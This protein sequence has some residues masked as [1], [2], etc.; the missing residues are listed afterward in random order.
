MESAQQDVSQRSHPATVSFKPALLGA[1]VLFSVFLNI[2]RFFPED[3]SALAF[4][5][6]PF[7]VFTGWG[8]LGCGIVLV[9]LAFVLNM[10]LAAL[11]RRMGP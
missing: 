8:L 11:R 4:S 5:L 2:L 7:A 9:A 3:E 1:G 10:G 6:N